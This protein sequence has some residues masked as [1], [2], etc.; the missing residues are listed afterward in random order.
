[1][2]VFPA[3]G[4]RWCLAPILG[5]VL[6]VLVGCGSEGG[7]DGTG[8][9]GGKGS[10]SDP[11]AGGLIGGADR[12]GEDA[13]GEPSGRILWTVT[14]ALPELRGLDTGSHET[15]LAVDVWKGSFQVTALSVADDYVWVGRE[16]SVVLAVDR[17]TGELAGERDLKIEVD[18]DYGPI[19]Q[20][21]AG[22][23]FAVTAAESGL[24]PPLVRIDAPQ[25]QVAKQGN[26]LGLAAYLNGIVYD[27]SDVWTISRNRLELVR[28][29][30]ETLEVRARV[31]LGRDPNNPDVFGDW[32][33]DGYLADAGDTLWVLDTESRRLTSVDK[34]TLT[35]RTAADL[36]DLS[37]FETYLEFDANSMGVFL[38]LN[39]PGLIVRFDPLTG[40]RLNTY[41]FSADGGVGTMAVGRDRLYMMDES[42]LAYD[43]KEVDIETGDIVQTI[44]SSGYLARIAAQK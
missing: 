9:A 34:A 30:P 12:E 24:E 27:G 4:R 33:G 13:K 17:K 38:L 40:Q 28:V 16:D 36:T 32:A 22:A 6:C 5:A 26:V 2:V 42:V 20:L 10:G 19:Y 35:P 25:L 41:D 21:A 43:I 15:V 3:L 8:G 23:G 39:E 29:D 7:S 31:E 18:G 37:D 1:M 14:S 44:H 11:G